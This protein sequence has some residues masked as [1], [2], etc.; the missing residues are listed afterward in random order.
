MRI[1]RKAG[2]NAWMRLLQNSGAKWINTAKTWPPAD[3]SEDYHRHHAVAGHEDLA[4]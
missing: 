4:V 3:N 2:K 1:A